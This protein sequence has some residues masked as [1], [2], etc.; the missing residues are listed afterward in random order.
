M[1]VQKYLGHC[2]PM[3][4]LDFVNNIIDTITPNLKRLAKNLLNPNK[5]SNFP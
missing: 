4:Y 1:A 2:I 5:N 3:I